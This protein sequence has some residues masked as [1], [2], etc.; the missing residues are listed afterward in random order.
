VNVIG[1]PES[2]IIL[3][4]CA[5]YL[6]TSA[7]SN[8]S[9]LAIGKAQEMVAKKPNLPVPIPLRNA[10]TKLMEQLG[11][12]EKYNYVH[13]NPGNFALQEYLPDEISGEIF[14]DPGKNKREEELREFLKIRW[15]NKYPY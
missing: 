10:P 15:K 6:A 2:R 1:W 13:D 7:K 12:G 4:Q 8:A 11:Y 9:Y 14:Y 3:S 5:I